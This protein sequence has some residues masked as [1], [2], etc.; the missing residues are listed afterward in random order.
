M[1]NRIQ[2]PVSINIDLT[3]DHVMLTSMG[4]GRD[5]VKAQNYVGYGL[6]KNNLQFN[7]NTDGRFKLNGQLSHQ[8]MLDIEYPE[9]GRPSMTLPD[10]RGHK[11]QLLAH[12]A[13][14]ITII[15]SG[16]TGGYVIRDMLRFLQSIKMKG[17]KRQFAVN[18][19]DDDVVEDKNLV[20]QNFIAS[21]VGQ[22]KCEVL[23][24]RYGNAFGIPVIA[25]DVR[26][27]DISMLRSIRQNTV[28]EVFTNPNALRSVGHII[29]GCV[30]NHAARRTIYEY[31]R[32][33]EGNAYW[34]DSGNERMSGQVV[35]GYGIAEWKR[36]YRGVDLTE[37]KSSNSIM[38]DNHH[39]PIPNV[40][41]VYPEILDPKQD[42]AGSDDTSCAER[43]LQEDQNIFINMTA[44]MH[45][46]NYVRQVV[47]SEKV[48]TNAITFDV[49]GLSTP[50]YNTP[51]YFHGLTK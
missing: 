21:D 24:R 33:Y 19:I 1:A 11:S 25:R 38:R 12:E 6:S 3:N 26:L 29:I 9:A 47:M 46:L 13:V 14:I 7:A 5:T 17:D 43:A 34:I 40:V 35:C 4:G 50:A 48:V 20:R 16:G 41:A 49:K 39:F 51:E 30:D 44:A 27:N 15:G 31:L 8:G 2:I 10:I 42:L 18:L 23:A 22:K 28:N 37:F 45:V 32:N 36:N